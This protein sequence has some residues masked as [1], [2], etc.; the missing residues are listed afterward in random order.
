MDYSAV[1]ILQIIGTL[2]VIPAW[3]W[4]MVNLIRSIFYGASDR[5]MIIP[6]LLVALGLS[7]S[8]T[9]PWYYPTIWVI[10]AFFNDVLSK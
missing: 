8:G 10:A 4:F 9:D 7:M 5:I 1:E 2:I 3:V 6:C